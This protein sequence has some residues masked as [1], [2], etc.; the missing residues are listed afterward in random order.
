MNLQRRR[1]LWCAAVACTPLLCSARLAHGQLRIVSYNTL[2]A[3]N[4]GVQTARPTAATVL[5]AIGLQS[6]NGIA[7]PIDVMLLQEQYTTEISTQSFV[8][9]LN[10]IYGP[11]TYARSTLNALASDFSLRRGGGPAMLYNTTT[12]QLINELRFGTV[13]GSNQARSAMRYQLRPV[14]YDAS[15]D[16][17][18]YSDHYKAGDTADDQTRRNIE[19]VA[20]R[21]NANALGEG[22][23]LIFAGDY[24]IQSSGEAMF[25]T[26]VAPGAGQANDPLNASGTPGSPVTWR[27]NSAYKAIHT[28][29]PDGPMDDRFDFQLVSGEML[30]G[31]G[32]S[33]VLNSYRTF[34]NNGTHS[35]NGAITTGSGA[36]AAVLSALRSNSDHLPVV[37]DY[38]LPAK[39]GV[40][41]AAVPPI[42][43]LGASISL[44]V[45]V[46]NIA[47]VVAAIGADELDYTLS[48]SGDLF[49]GA[50]GIDLALGG[51]NVH[52]VTLSTATPGIKSGV[53]TVTSTS[54]GAANALQTFPVQF[55]VAAPFLAA[56]FNENGFVDGVDLATWQTNFGLAE[57]ATKSVG[58]AN[59]DGAVDGNDY[60]LWQREFDAAASSVAS[61]SVPE[62]AAAAMV[63]LGMALVMRRRR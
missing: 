59:L 39:M 25:Q 33:I 36:S 31:E 12:V 53:L 6:V 7:K 50:V 4:P 13:N 11:G 58:D 60:L 40:E 57:G 29:D 37:A 49:G 34:G 3:E 15:A 30:D 1:L 47:S 63:L 35:L 41:L 14:G 5:E 54:Q 16:F 22:A 56:D 27:D 51:G 21:N 32:M 9:V 8:D 18:A 62:P 43:T 23:H 45:T 26:L 55:E 24:N 19:A 2:T 28:Q 38:Q 20:V 10:G 61:A 44:D 52:Q 42:V 46:S 48:V 17:Y